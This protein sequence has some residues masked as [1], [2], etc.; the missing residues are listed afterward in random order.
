MKNELNFDVLAA[1]QV[2]FS[3]SRQR[4]G[5]VIATVLTQMLR[6]LEHDGLV[7]SLVIA[8]APARVD[9]APTELG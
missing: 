7:D 8:Q 2:R 9:Y 4:I 1:E 6:R 3:V 5:T